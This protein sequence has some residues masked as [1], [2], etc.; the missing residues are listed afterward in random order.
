MSYAGARYPLALLLHVYAFSFTHVSRSSPVPKTRLVP[1]QRVKYPHVMQ[2]LIL[3]L[4]L[5][6]KD[7]RVIKLSG[8]STQGSQN[9]SQD[10]QCSIPVGISS[11]RLVKMVTRCALS[12]G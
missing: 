3:K 6:W 12:I 9:Y 11:F 1:Q 7:V 5:I 8:R 4:H 2:N 10:K